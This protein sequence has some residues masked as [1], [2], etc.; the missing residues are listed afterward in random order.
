[1]KILNKRAYLRNIIHTGLSNYMHISITHPIS[2]EPI[3]CHCLLP[4]QPN[5]SIRN[6]SKN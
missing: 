4:M 5:Q 1:M 3:S 6:I 2:P